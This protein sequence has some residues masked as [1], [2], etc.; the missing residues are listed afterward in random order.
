LFWNRG[1][2]ECHG[3]PEVLQAYREVFRMGLVMSSPT[4]FN[5]V[6]KFAALR[7]MLQH[8]TFTWEPGDE[9]LEHRRRSKKF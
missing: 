6:I 7:A 8:W 2:T 1:K 5:Q 3:I 4:N 9:I